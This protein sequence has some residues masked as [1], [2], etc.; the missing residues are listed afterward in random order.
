MTTDPTD[1]RPQSPQ[2]GNDVEHARYTRGSELI[3]AI[4]GEAGHGV[5]EA[6]ADVAPGLAHHIVAHAY[7]EVFTRPGLTLA[8]R[9]LITLGTLTA[10]GDCEAQLDIH[11]NASLNVGLS[12]TE[13]VET[14]THAA[15]YCG[16]PKALNAIL[17]VKRVFADRG[18]LP[19]KTPTGT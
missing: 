16:F 5:L 9:Q 6:L 4:V 2:L 18:L 11:I 13:I 15:V 10:L 8:Q 7:G 1:P 12:P 14:I 3:D 19:V 17:V